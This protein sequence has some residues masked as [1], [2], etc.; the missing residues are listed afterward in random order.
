[1]TAT[2]GPVLTNDER[3]QCLQW[4]DDRWD[5]LAPGVREFLLRQWAHPGLSEQRRDEVCALYAD[6]RMRAI[7]LR[8]GVADWA[9]ECPH[10]TCPDPQEAAIEHFDDL[11]REALFTLTNGAGEG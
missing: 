7:A 3:I 4:L 5:H 9:D 11:A 1:M 6:S 10:L 2:T 8:D